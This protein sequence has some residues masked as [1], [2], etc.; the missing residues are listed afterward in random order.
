MIVQLDNFVLNVGSL[1]TPTIEY[2]ISVVLTLSYILSTGICAC[3]PNMR[4][5]DVPSRT[6]HT[7]V[8]G[9]VHFS[10]VPY[11]FPSQ[12]HMHNGYLQLSLYWV[13][14]FP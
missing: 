3:F 13:W 5:K 11:S 8:I 6:L 7:S 14:P 12:K 10:N 1:F 9:H 4:Q 2:K